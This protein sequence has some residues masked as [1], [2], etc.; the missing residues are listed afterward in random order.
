MKILKNVILVWSVAV[1]TPSKC[2]P[3]LYVVIVLSFP[4][5][6]II[7]FFSSPVFFH[8]YFWEVNFQDLTHSL[9]FFIYSIFI[10]NWTMFFLF[11]YPWIHLSS[12]LHLSITYFFSSYPYMLF[13][14]QLI[15]F[16]IFYCQFPSHFS[17]Y[18]I[19]PPF[20]FFTLSVKPFVLFLY[21]FIQ[22]YTFDPFHACLEK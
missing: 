12:S 1:C 19:C 21:L 9:W 7:S 3:T 2:P 16:P 18:F 11:V 10:S 8:K 14:C 5:S 17:P 13:S 20:C 6:L 4:K 22:W 15:F